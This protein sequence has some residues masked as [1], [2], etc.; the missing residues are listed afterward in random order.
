MINKS[1]F[2][3]LYNNQIIV[4]LSVLAV[5]WLLLELIGVVVAGFIAY[6]IMAA[7]APLVYRLAARGVPKSLAAA[8]VYLLVVAVIVL[9]I[10]PLVPFFTTQ[11]MQLVRGL[12]QYIQNA[13]ELLGIRTNQAELQNIFSSQLGAI[14]SN[15]LQVT[16]QVF[17][18]IFTILTVIV[19]SFYLLLDHVRVQKSIASLFA[20]SVRRRASETIEK[21]EDKLGAW[22]RGQ[23]TLSFVVTW[24]GLTAIGVEYALPL[25]LLAG[26]LEIVPTIGPIIAAIPAMIV[27]LSISPT[28]AI[29]VAVLYALIQILEN[30]FLVPRI[31]Q[32]AVGLHPIVVILGIIIGGKL[33]GVLGALLAVPFISLVVVIA[34]E[35]N[36]NE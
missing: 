11:T 15:A 12:P 18:G 2:R 31:M 16:S 21:V 14:G 13:T 26:M 10:F 20:P 29:F 25:A 5:A 3:Y 9:L 17:G 35:I 1:L 36:K 19:L 32:R 27:A 4:A 8:A 28:V 6:I 22:L 33:L 34:T 30:N 7:I 24:L 23:I